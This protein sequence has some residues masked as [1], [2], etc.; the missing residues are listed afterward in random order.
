MDKIVGSTWKVWLSTIP[1]VN[2]DYKVLIFS[3]ILIVVS[4]ENL[5]SIP[6]YILLPTFSVL[7]STIA[8]PSFATN[9][10]SK[11]LNRLSCISDCLNCLRKPWSF[12][13]LSLFLWRVHFPTSLCCPLL[14]CILS[15]T[16]TQ[17]NITT[18]RFL[19]F[20]PTPRPLVNPPKLLSGLIF[21]C[22]VT[23]W[24]H[25]PA[26]NLSARLR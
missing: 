12:Y 2:T 1:L 16:S 11:D 14:G 10:L 26:Q 6:C 9:Q 18:H 15:S 22:S 13:R 5:E 21:V 24:V 8:S 20:L 17:R 23:R 3:L 25:S 7:W 4:V 19:L